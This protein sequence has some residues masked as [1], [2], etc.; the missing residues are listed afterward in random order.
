MPR[1][2][3]TAP[4]NSIQI[5]TLHLGQAREPSGNYG[6]AT[7]VNSGPTSPPRRYLGWSGASCATLAGTGS[8]QSRGEEAMKSPG[9]RVVSIAVLAGAAAPSAL[10]QSAYPSQTVKLMVPNPAGGLP[11]TVARIVG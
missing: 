10:A 3:I 2:I 6:G 4:G 1:N 11:D 8:K 9:L 7:T 5:P